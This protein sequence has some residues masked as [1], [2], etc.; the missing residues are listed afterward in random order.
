MFIRAATHHDG[1]RARWEC[2]AARR[3]QR[4]DRTDRLAGVQRAISPRGESGGAGQPVSVREVRGDAWRGG[5]I[6]LGALLLTAT[7]VS[8]I[9][10]REQGV[11]FTHAGAPCYNEIRDFA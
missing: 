6:K 3:Q 11:L 1:D 10:Q 5:V 9:Q 2:L 8:P 4:R 7:L